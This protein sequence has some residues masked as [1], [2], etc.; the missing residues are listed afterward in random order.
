MTIDFVEC[1]VRDPEELKGPAT[2][3]ND[4]T[5]NSPLLAAWVKY[6]TPSPLTGEGSP[7]EIILIET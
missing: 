5:W 1:Q 7:C 4:L 3:L 2:N 6:N